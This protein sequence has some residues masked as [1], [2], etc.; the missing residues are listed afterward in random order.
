MTRRPLPTR[1]PICELPRQRGSRQCSCG[2]DFSQV[3]PSARSW[4]KVPEALVG[5]LVLVLVIDVAATMAAL[6]L[7]I[8]S[9]DWQPGMMRDVL[10][11]VHIAAGTANGLLL[12]RI[13]IASGAERITPIVIYLLGMI[14]CF[15]L[16]WVV[17]LVYLARWKAVAPQP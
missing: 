11:L 2:F 15:P 13:L 16:Q 4:Q 5:R 14:L 1:C 10:V 7:T 8:S 6:Y 17:L 3:A 12:H 9:P